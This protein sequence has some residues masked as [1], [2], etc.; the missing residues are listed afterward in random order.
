MGT[1]VIET[2]LEIGTLAQWASATATFLAVLVALFKDEMLRWWRKPKLSVSIALASPDC[3]KTKLT[4]TIQKT[5]LTYVAADCYYL[6]M[7]VTNVGKTR[8]ERVQVFASKLSRQSADSS[9][10]EVEAFLPMNLRWAHGQQAGNVPE[11]FAEGISPMMGKHCDLGHV[12]DPKFRKDIGEDLAGV[13]DDQTILSLDLEIKPNTLSHLITPGV[14][15]LEL[16]VAAANSAPVTKVIEITITGK[17]FE[18][19]AK[20]FTDGLGLRII[21]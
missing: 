12:M 8:A 6:R 19:Q 15:R 9:F 18:E 21:K 4:Y 3:H 10:K 20:M 11:I 16:R 2:T 1:P 7:W 14:Y 5:A 13:P 17:W